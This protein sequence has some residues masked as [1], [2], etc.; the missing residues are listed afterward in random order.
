MIFI[1]LSIIPNLYVKIIKHDSED[2]VAILFFAII[3][4]TLIVF[5]IQ[6]YIYNKKHDI[7]TYRI[8][9]DVKIIHCNRC[10]AR[11]YKDTIHKCWKCG[12]DITNENNI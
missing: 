11:Y 9:D 4:F 10:R 2:I 12:N 3:I 6:K 8:D 1:E 7:K 5:L